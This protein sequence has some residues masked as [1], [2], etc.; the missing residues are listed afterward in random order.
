MVKRKNNVAQNSQTSCY[1]TQTIPKPFICLTKSL[2]LQF[3]ILPFV[4]TVNNFLPPSLPYSLLES[5][6]IDCILCA[7]A[8][9]TNEKSRSRPSEAL[10]YLSRKE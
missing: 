5:S 10:Y 8:S 9:L 6:S 4:S 2:G 1:F 7:S 3:I